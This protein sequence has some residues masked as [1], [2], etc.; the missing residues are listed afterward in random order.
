MRIMIV[1]GTFDNNGG[2]PSSVIRRM[3]EFIAH[4][5]EHDVFMHNGQHYNTLPAIFEQIKFYDAVIW[6]PNVPN[7]LDKV[8]N[9]KEVYPNKILVTSKRNVGGNYKLSQLLNHALG[10]HSNL[11]VEFVMDGDLYASRILDPLGVVWCDYTTNIERMTTALLMRMEDLSRFTRVGAQRQGD[12]LEVP[13]EEYFFSIV[14]GY[15]ETFHKLVN[16]DKDV[17][18]FLGN[19]SFRCQRGF[20]SFRHE[21]V[22]FVSRRN[23][24]K[25]FID[26]S[27]FVATHMVG[28]RVGY[29]GDFKPSVDTP[30]QLE[31]YDVFPQVN[32]MIHSHTYIEDAPFTCNPVPCGAVEE[33]FEILAAVHDRDIPRFAVNLIGHGSLIAADSVQYLEDIP[34]IS[35]PAPEILEAMVI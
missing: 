33:V 3:F 30:I 17:T 34:Y 26:Q 35:R 7:E 20:P 14:R 31:I 1:G 12:A 27:G 19:S 15:A 11:L 13:N 24:D 18:R 23:V 21:G 9:I 28:G 5:S 10:L 6:F 4:N 32:Y 16:P 22:V 29:Y 25:R 2:K 8:R